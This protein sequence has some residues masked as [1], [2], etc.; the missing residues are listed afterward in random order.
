V[1][2][3]PP[4]CADQRG[5]ERFLVM[6]GAKASGTKDICMSRFVIALALASL[7]LEMPIIAVG[8]LPPS[9]IPACT[10]GKV[11]GKRLNTGRLRYVVPKN[12]IVRKV[13]DVD[14]GEY[15]VFLNTKSGWEALHLFSWGNGTPD[16]LCSAVPSR[17]LQLPD[18]TEGRDARCTKGDNKEARST[19]FQSE[20]A[21]YDS[22]S[23]ESAQSF[24]LIID[25][26]CY[27]PGK[28]R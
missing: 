8:E 14:Y 5:F 26:M 9:T 17:T 13:R 15:R 3:S 25:S 23:A 11:N 10:N 21:F 19:G 1:T 28:N 27:A 22:V 12:L 16:S 4:I 7:T 20:F 2:S 6:T 24:D 18:G